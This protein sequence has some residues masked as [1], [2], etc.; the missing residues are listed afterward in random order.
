MTS[1]TMRQEAYIFVVDASKMMSFKEA[2]RDFHYRNEGSP[3]LIN[4]VSGNNYMLVNRKEKYWKVVS[5]EWV[6]DTKG[7]DLV[8][9]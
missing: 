8:T 4:D 3:E 5:K 7:I 1:E 9:Y 6:K 2:M